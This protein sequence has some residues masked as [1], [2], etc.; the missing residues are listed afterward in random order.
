[1]LVKGGPEN[2]LRNNYVSVMYCVCWDSSTRNI[3]HPQYSKAKKKHVVHVGLLH[4]TVRLYETSLSIIFPYRKHIQ[5]KYKLIRFVGIMGI[6]NW[7]HYM[8]YDSA[9]RTWL[10]QGQH[11]Q[12]YLCATYDSLWYS[13]PAILFRIF[14][15]RVRVEWLRRL[16]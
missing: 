1:M 7:S 2:K 8:R 13:D 6:P 3:N 4:Y 5:S 14:D 16:T 10:W 12:L 15:G 11:T 9:K